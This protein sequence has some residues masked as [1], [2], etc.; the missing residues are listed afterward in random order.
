MKITRQDMGSVAVL[1]VAGRLDTVTAPDFDKQWEN[2]VASDD[3]KVVMDLGGLEYVSSA[4]L[5][6]LLVAGKRLKRGGGALAVSG[7][8]GMVAEVFAI[9]GFDKL[10]PLYGE[11]AEAV[12]AL[13]S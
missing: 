11:V 3:L 2:V 1:A 9:S 12:T 6:C 5:R 4:G 7:L 8:T 13:E 10:L